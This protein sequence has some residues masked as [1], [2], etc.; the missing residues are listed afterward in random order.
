MAKPMMPDQPG[1]T[2]VTGRVLILLDGS[3]QSLAALDVAAEIAHRRGAQVLGIFVEEQNLLRS[4]GYGFAREVG[5]SSGAVRPLD[6]GQL[7]A[8]LEA[9]AQQ[10]RLA[11][12][13]AMSSRGIAQALT[14]CRGQVPEEVLGLVQPEDL[15]ILGQVG[16]SGAPGI[17]LGSTARALMRRAPGDVLLWADGVQ[18]GARQRVVVVL[19]H[20][21]GA[22]HRAIRVGAELAARHHQ[23]MSVLLRASGDEDGQVAEDILSYLG[24]QGIS[25]RV[26]RLPM[27]TPAA[28]IRSLKEERAAHLILSRQSSLFLDQGA[29]ALLEQMHLPVTV[30]P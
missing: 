3:R 30:T 1:P 2:Q 4:A 12:A 19:N 8:R 24:Q 20:D 7:Q 25:A 28:L 16:W 29:E 6:S 11:L 23:P 21:Q 26:R 14:L 13:R 5:S 18:A 17:R 15:L 9:M 10:A 22:N 27:A